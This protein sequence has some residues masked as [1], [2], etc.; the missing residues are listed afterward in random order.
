MVGRAVT[1]YRA[2]P[3]DKTAQLGHLNGEREAETYADPSCRRP[4]LGDGVRVSFA[5]CYE[6]EMPALTRF[7]MRLGADPHTAADAAHTAFE[8]AYRQWD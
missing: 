2:E 1:V 5:R 6:E 4:S 7:V 3:P 8:D